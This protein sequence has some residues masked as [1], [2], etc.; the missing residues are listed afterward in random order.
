HNPAAAVPWDLH[1]NG[2]PI[3]IQIVAG[4]GQDM[5][6]LRISAAIEAARPWGHRWPDLAT[7]SAVPEP[8]R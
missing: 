8:V 1:S 6:V 2:L 5:R 3:G 4:H 7:A